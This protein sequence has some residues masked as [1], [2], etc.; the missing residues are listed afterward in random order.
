MPKPILI[1]VGD[2]MC[3]WC[4]GLASVMEKILQNYAEKLDFEVLLGGLRPGNQAVVDEEMADFLRHHWERV[5]ELSGQKFDFSLLEKRGWFYNTEPACRAVISARALFGSLK[6]FG[7]FK[8]LQ[9][10]YYAQGQ[11]I[12]S[13]EVIEQLAIDAGF[14]GAEFMA[15][16]Q[17]DE[18]K[19]VTSTE[20]QDVSAMGVSGF[21]TL[22][23]VHQGEATLLLNGYGDYDNVSNR[24]DSFLA[25]AD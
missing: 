24:L 2:P 13:D 14:D 19:T 23:M 25:D 17:K 10:S 22:I 9:Q 5:H 20:F 12:T 7:F 18:M 1:Y 16:F 8:F 15:L 21:P 4:W 6:A 3:S 11:I